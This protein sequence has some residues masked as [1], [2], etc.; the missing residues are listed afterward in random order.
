MT[1]GILGGQQYNFAVGSNGTLIAT[2]VAPTSTTQ[3]DDLTQR[4]DTTMQGFFILPLT[5]PRQTIIGG[6]RGERCPSFQ[7]YSV[8][9]NPLTI[10]PPNGCGSASTEWVPELDFHDCCNGHDACYSMS[11]TYFLLSLRYS[12]MNLP[13]NCSK[14]WSSCNND[15]Y[16]CM[17][18]ACTTLY[19]GE[20]L[21]QW[22]CQLA[23]G[24]Y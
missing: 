12:L 2:L 1:A 22:G 9:K 8:F 16:D 14:S 10:P 13:G 3:R 24:T 5:A 11:Y 7:Q 17:S 20:S 15:F 21:Y 18:A 6:P 23:A 19:Q 4:D